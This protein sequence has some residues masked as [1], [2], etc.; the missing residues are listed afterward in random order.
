M[1]FRSKYTHSLAMMQNKTEASELR[2]E[3]AAIMAAG[4]AAERAKKSE[5]ANDIARLKE[6]DVQ[7]QTILQELVKRVLTLERRFLNPKRTKVGAAKV[8][9]KR[10]KGRG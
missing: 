7:T 9:N 4:D 3:H 2:K 6:N 1:L 10:R 8:I 5:T